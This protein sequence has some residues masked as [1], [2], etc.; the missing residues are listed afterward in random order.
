MGQMDLKSFA[1]RIK[2]SMRE[3]LFWLK[4]QSANKYCTVNEEEA[5]KQLKVFSPQPSSTAI[6]RNNI[7]ETE[8][9]LTIIIP[10]YNSAEWIQEC[11]DSVLGQIT[12]YHFTVLV[13]N[14]GS[15]DETGK[16][17]KSYQTNPH[18]QIIEQN[19]KGYS[20]ARNAGLHHIISKYI[21][22]VDSDD[23]LLQGAVEALMKTAYQLDAD[24]VEGNGFRFV[25]NKTLG[26]IK[27]NDDS[28][29]GGPVLKVIRSRLFE[30]IVFPD[31]YL[32]EDRIIESLIFSRA[33]NI[34]TIPDSVYAY[35][36]HEKSIT[37]AHDNNPKRLDSYWIMLLMQE[38]RHELGLQ[39][40]YEYYVKDMRQI[41]MT[42]RRTVC[43]PETIK[44]SIFVQTRKYILTYYSEYM[45]NRDKCYPL[46]YAIKNANYGKYKVF[47]ENRMI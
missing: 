32:Y 17:I 28:L 43:F 7:D 8:V 34:K 20:G 33:K 24:I 1:K 26:K 15:T 5:E 44:Q 11:L 41:V 27:S 35:R 4:Y 46:A 39:I 19:N 30:N 13:I 6:Y 38:N 42:Y 47:C 12:N 22:F 18:L 3:A 29:W 31:G 23:I 45:D 25:G 36:I 14:D 40:N 37:Q 9:D 16:I 10:A 2:R 21:M